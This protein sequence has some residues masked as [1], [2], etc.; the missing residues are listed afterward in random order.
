MSTL[1]RALLVLAGLVASLGAAVTPAAAGGPAA[2]TWR[3]LTSPQPP[4]RENGAMAY[5][6]ATRQVVL[7][8]GLNNN[9]QPISDTWIWNGKTWKEVVPSQSPSVRFGASMAY[10][11][12]TGQ[13][14]LFGG[15][16]VVGG[17]GH[18]GEL[19]D[20]WIWSG[21]T[22]TELS[23]ASRPGGRAYASLAYDAATRQLVLFGGENPDA[24]SF[25]SD[26]WTWNGTT[27]TEASASTSVLGAR[28]GT[29]MAYD[30]AAHKLVLFGGQNSGGLDLGDTWTWNGSSWAESHPSTAPPTLGGASMG[31]DQATGQLV[32]FGG[33]D[34]GPLLNQTWTWSGATWS[35]STPS[36]SPP[37][38]A[39]ATMAYDAHTSQLLLFS[40]Y[41]ALDDT[42]T[43]GVVA[44]TAGPPRFVKAT[45]GKDKVTL[46]WKAP[47]SDGG[48][49]VT[50][51]DVYEGTKSGHEA[52]KPLTAKPLSPH[53][54]SF[55]V[56]GLN[57]GVKY[58]FV[59]RAINAVGAGAASH[60]ASATPT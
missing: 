32:L 25:Y 54:S 2:P 29:A 12:A 41:P 11:A 24:F 14:V 51:Y 23:P 59:V 3:Q 18:G 13:L 1:A 37:A 30:A 36:K 17:L 44:T 43:W 9:Y 33:Q 50:G 42:W 58:Y 15:E 16:E 5:D 21:R 8:G 55:V 52:S 39:F 19:N 46:S 6:P 45:A 22:W 40:G 57:K 31:Y 56:R 38:R 10:D 35:R 60:Q 34:A 48:S 4:A 7:F 20:T 53:A 26:T 49:A 47:T 28:D 27:W